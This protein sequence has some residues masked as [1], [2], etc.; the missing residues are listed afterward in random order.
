[1]LDRLQTVA[2]LVLDHSECAEVFLRHRIDFCCG[3]GRSLE[4]A[5]AEKQVAL[6][7]LLA[8][9]QAAIDARGQAPASD[10]RAQA[11]PELL[12]SLVDGHHAPV[13]RALPMAR[14]LA[15]KVARVHG[16]HN[17]KLVTLQE[18]VEALAAAL[19]AHADEQERTL[20]PSLTASAPDRA[21]LA[22]TA[23]ELEELSALLGRV[24]ESSEDFTLPEWACNSY[25]T[26]FRELEAL[27]RGV[28]A[29]M[30]VE[31]HV[32]LPRFAA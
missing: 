18:A 5:A 23:R 6:D 15:A 9:L 24:R 10:P 3:G 27:E 30:H 19:T 12:T 26:L 13:R 29:H 22:A 7:A 17:P 21:A 20:F 16:A 4:A 11:T 32:L 25:R 8:E 1:M 14:Q 28:S 2:T 31:Q